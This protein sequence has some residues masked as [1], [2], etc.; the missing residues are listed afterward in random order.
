MGQLSKAKQ[1]RR[2]QLKAEI[3]G[4]KGRYIFKRGLSWG[5]P[6]LLVYF[7]LAA[8]AHSLLGQI[9]FV[10]GLRALFPFTVLLGF[11]SFG[12]GGYFVGRHHWFKLLAE[13]GPKDKKKK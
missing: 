2:R 8:A 7:F 4:G 13:A 6:I 11:A 1:A 12:I 5:L 10:Q 9:T 3:A